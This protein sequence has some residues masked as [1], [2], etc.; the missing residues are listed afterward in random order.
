MIYYSHA[1]IGDLQLETNDAAVALASYRKAQEIINTLFQAD[2]KSQEYRIDVTATLSRIGDIMLKTDSA[3]KSLENYRRAL[4]LRE[5]L[6]E[7]G[8]INITLCLGTNIIDS[9][10]A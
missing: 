5:E 7:E 8:P 10:R 6:I 4:Q 3:S 2:P 9:R 1:L